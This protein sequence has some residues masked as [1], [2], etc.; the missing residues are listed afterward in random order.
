MERPLRGNVSE[1]VL[2]LR[3]A[4]WYASEG[5]QE[6][7]AQQETL[8]QQAALRLSG[9]ALQGAPAEGMPQA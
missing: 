4:E 6:L 1:S 8:R 7:M 3:F 2:D 9:P 5:Y